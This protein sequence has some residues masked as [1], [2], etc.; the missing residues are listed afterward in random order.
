MRTT[1]NL[2]RI[3]IAANA[4][5]VYPAM[6]PAIQ[7]ICT[8]IEQT[9]RLYPD[10]PVDLAKRDIHRASKWIRIHPAMASGLM[11]A[12]AGTACGQN[13]DFATSTLALAFGFTGPPWV[14]LFDYRRN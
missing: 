14:L 9:H 8:R 2:R 4:Q 11:N 12:I 1:S 6:V 7:E 5:K 10:A 3:N 13:A